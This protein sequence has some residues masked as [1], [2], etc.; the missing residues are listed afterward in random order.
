MRVEKL[1]L[2]SLP[3]CHHF[4]SVYSDNIPLA[5]YD[6]CHVCFVLECDFARFIHSLKWMSERKLIKLAILQCV[7]PQFFKTLA[8]DNV[9]VQMM[10]QLTFWIPSPTVQFFLSISPRNNIKV[11]NSVQAVSKQQSIVFSSISSEQSWMIS[12]WKMLP[13]TQLPF[14]LVLNYSFHLNGVKQ[15]SY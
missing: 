15:M 8:D 10:Q 3:V 1:K 14:D 12:F 13:H 11:H 5:D 9:S 4:N 7:E 6:L 2:F